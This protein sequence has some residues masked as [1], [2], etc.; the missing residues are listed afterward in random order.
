MNDF[1]R[2]LKGRTGLYYL[3]L[4]YY[5]SVLLRYE[6]RLSNRFVRGEYLPVGNPETEFFYGA[7]RKGERLDL[8]SVRPL[9]ADHRVYAT[10]YNRA[11]FPVWWGKIDESMQQLDAAE[12]GAYYLIRAHRLRPAAERAGA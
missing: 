2:E 9:L 7:L 3:C 8:S 5:V 4:H 11:S 10:I 1:Y 6:K 12:A